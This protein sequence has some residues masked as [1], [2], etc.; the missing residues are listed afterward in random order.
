[1]RQL[2]LPYPD[3]EELFRRMVFNVICYNCDDHTKN[4]SFLMD[5]NGEWRLSPAY[6]VTYA[7]NP[8]NRWLKAHQMSVN[9]K[10]ENLSEEDLLAVANEM[11]IKK[12]KSII[13]S[14]K[15]AASLWP[16]FAD[17]TGMPRNQTESIGRLIKSR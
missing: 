15:D 13:A 11:N 12:A 8:D 1:M 14:V 2:R 9:G 3:A 7:Y 10:R 6:D 17:E 16:E 5:R 4:I